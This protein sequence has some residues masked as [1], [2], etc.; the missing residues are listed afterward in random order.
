MF[1][2]LNN[3]RF[4]YQITK[5][6]NYCLNLNNIP[7]K[8]VDKLF[9]TDDIF[10]I[11]NI[12][13]IPLK[14]LP[15]Y[16]IVYNF[17]QLITEQKWSKMF[18]YKI[19]KALMVFDYSVRNLEVLKSHSITG[20][21][22]PYGWTPILDKEFKKKEI[23]VIFLGMMN[24]RRKNVLNEITEYNSYFDNNT[25]H[26]K[27]D[28][29]ISKSKI[30]LNIHYYKKETILEVPRILPL[31][32]NNI[33][34]ISEKSDDFFYDNKLKDIVIFCELQEFKEVLKNTIENYSLTDAVIK[35]KLLEKRLNYNNIIKS[36]KDLFNEIIKN[37]E[38][39]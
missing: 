22:L 30:S 35:K 20:Y 15:K 17:E 3:S 18:F 24:E 21:H 29:I 11:L 32:S 34:I 7:S 31:I 4:L 12:Y 8:L 38:N 27:Y 19:K 33:L 14:K 39:I 2:I 5:S 16:F 36:N 37:K 23:D 6:L 9:N 25:F 13:S 28:E 10:I 1:L 26:D